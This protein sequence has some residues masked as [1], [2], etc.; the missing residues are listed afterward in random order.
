MVSKKDAFKAGF[1]GAL[2]VY[3]A[4][5]IIGVVTALIFGLLALVGIGVLA[6]GGDDKPAPEESTAQVE[7]VPAEETD[8]SGDGYEFD[9]DFECELLAQQLEEGTDMTRK[10]FVQSMKG[11]GVSGDD[12]RDVADCAGLF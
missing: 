4:M 2:G 3:V 7:E 6:G 5:L 8:T 10:E 12:A 11:M 9:A 1:F